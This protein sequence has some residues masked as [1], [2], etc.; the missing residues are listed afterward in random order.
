MFILLRVLA[1]GFAVK[2]SPHALATLVTNVPLRA[3]SSDPHASTGGSARST[4][5]PLL[6][7][8]TVALTGCALKT[9][10]PPAAVLVRALQTSLAA[11]SVGCLSAHAAVTYGYG[12]GLVGHA[13]AMA[14]V[15]AAGPAPT[16]V[17]ATI[18]LYGVK[19]CL[20]QLA[21][22]FGVRGYATK[23]TEP[24]FRYFERPD[25]K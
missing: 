25:T 23:V 12:A 1:C 3:L 10:S 2:H 21:R 16:L 22:D 4:Q 11:S 5:S 19:V 15:V 20:L 14:P 13:A 9:A 6:P 24:G 7:L 18:L 17:R 8:L